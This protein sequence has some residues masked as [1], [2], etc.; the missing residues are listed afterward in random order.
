MN[1]TNMNEPKDEVLW[2]IAKERVG[3]R[4][5]LLSYVFVNLFLIGIW[6]FGS[7]GNLDHFWPIWPILGWGIGLVF[8]YLKAYHGNKVN[9]VEKEYQKLK[10]N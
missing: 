1:N 6:Y 9:N 8:Q 4:W 7:K 2:Q 3:F 10:N 5:S